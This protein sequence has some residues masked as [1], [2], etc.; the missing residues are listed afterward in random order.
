VATKSTKNREK[1]S[2]IFVFFV[3]T[4]FQSDDVLNELALGK[5][6]TPA[7]ASGLSEHVWT[8]KELVERAVA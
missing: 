6:T 2:C 8:I 5:N 4:L 1:S 7:M 3:A